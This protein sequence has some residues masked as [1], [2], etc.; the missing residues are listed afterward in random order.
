MGL[1]RRAKRSLINELQLSYTPIL[2]QLTPKKSLSLRRLGPSKL[3]NGAW[4]VCLPV[5]VSVPTSVATALP[6]RS[7]AEENECEV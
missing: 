5:C 2:C 1:N 4:P 3:S 7:D 6:S